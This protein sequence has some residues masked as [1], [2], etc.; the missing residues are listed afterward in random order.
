MDKKK[1]FEAGVSS[2]QNNTKKDFI[3]QFT[4]YFAIIFGL[5]II[6]YLLAILPS[7]LAKN[8]PKVEQT[9]L[10]IEDYSCN[11]SVTKDSI[12]YNVTYLI[13]KNGTQIGTLEYNF[14]KTG[15]GLIKKE[16]S[17][18]DFTKL[19]DYSQAIKNS[20]VSLL[21]SAITIIETI[22]DLDYNC[23]KSSYILILGN[24][25][26]NYSGECSPP[27]IPFKICEQNM[28]ELLNEKI[29]AG[30]FTFNATKYE[31]THSQ[32]IQ[33]LKETQTLFIWFSDLPFPIKVG[34]SEFYLI[35]SNYSKNNINNENK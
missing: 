10:F 11:S 27:D 32:M 17:T 33:G 26:Y 12:E 30:A 1:K 18:I 3:K 24:S 22:Y 23:K 20:N 31:Y 5:M 16:I 15:Y 7:L 35:L 25:T 2:V 9:E 34:D 29:E 21:S 13:I 28:K 19:K 6:A 4:F 8:S 14:S